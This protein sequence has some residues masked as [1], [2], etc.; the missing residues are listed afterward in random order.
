MLLVHS[1]H[2]EEQD[3]KEW[4]SQTMGGS[5]SGGRTEVL[6][7]PLGY[8]IEGPS[9]NTNATLENRYIKSCKQRTHRLNQIYPRRE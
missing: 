4:Y 8:G 1:P 3:L 5:Q 6:F 2:F 7:I 9:S